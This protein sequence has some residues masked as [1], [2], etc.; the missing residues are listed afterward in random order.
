M[1]PKRKGGGEN[2]RFSVASLLKTGVPLF[3]SKT[4][5][6]KFEKARRHLGGRIALLF[7]LA[8]FFAA[9][10]GFAAP[11]SARR[12][13]PQRIVSLVPSLT[14]TLFALGAGPQVVGVSEYC[15]WPPETAALPRVGNFLAPVAEVV[16]ALKPDLV[17]TSPSPGNE[18]VVAT[19]RR[20]GLRV[21]VVYGDRSLDEIRAVLKT[22]AALVGR[23]EEGAAL[24]AGLDRDFE[25]V[26]RRAAT[27][28]AVAVALV[29]PMRP[30]VLA[31]VP[32][33]LGELLELAGGRNVAP[34][35]SG[36]W[37]RLGW[38]FLVASAPEVIVDVSMGMSGEGGEA[39]AAVQARWAEYAAL[40]AVAAGRVNTAD[41]DVLMRP[42][43]RVGEAARL[44]LAFL[45]PELALP[46]QE[47]AT[48]AVTA[49]SVQRP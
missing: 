32:S 26:R 37:P 25:A 23:V 7:A 43:P 49:L 14:E 44:L 15:N 10:T 35:S 47:K 31:G 48:A 1:P 21:E 19:L 38:E 20:A 41:P 24:I 17:L 29:I 46:P 18:A 6:K 34:A 11:D 30:L 3:H 27:V 36:R 45:H 8:C 4:N 40:P 28:E 22:T 16:V 13:S 2:S 39:D 5:N 9:T 33:Y 42:G 12:T